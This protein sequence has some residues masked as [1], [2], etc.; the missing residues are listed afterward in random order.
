VTEEKGEDAVCEGLNLQ[1]SK[2]S[3]VCCTHDWQTMDRF[4]WR[5]F[6]I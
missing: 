6:W 5:H 3:C 2:Q 1:T 4:S